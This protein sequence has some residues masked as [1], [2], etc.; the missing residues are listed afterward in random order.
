MLQSD[1]VASTTKDALGSIL[2][3][4]DDPIN[5]KFSEVAMDGKSKIVLCPF[6][7]N[8]TIART[9]RRKHHQ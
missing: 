3:E 1:T 8:V 6:P 5:E 7:V 9:H 4:D 2:D